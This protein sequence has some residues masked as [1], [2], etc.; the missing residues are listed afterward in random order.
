[1]RAAATNRLATLGEMAT[2]LAHELNQPLAVMTLAAENS[3]RGLRLRGADAIGDVI[4]RL[5]RVSAQGRRARNIIDHLRIFGRPDEERAVEALALSEVV[6]GA[7]LLTG[8][9]LREASIEVE[10]EISPELPNI[11]GRLIPYEQVLVNLILNARDAIQSS[12]VESGQ[13]RL[14]AWVQEERLRLSVADNGGG[15]PEAVLGRMFEPFFTTKPPG[16]GT[17][18]GLPF[19]LATMRG[20]GGDIL[21]DNWADGAIFRLDFPLART[22][23]TSELVE[24][25]VSPAASG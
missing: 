12:G 25:T 7:L 3:V 21:A 20:L 4:V 2:G 19:C 5:S 10:Q 23:V 11:S 1:M 24:V 18:V 14:R 13:I 15:I 16:K 8:A 9:A 6:D 22:D 17:G